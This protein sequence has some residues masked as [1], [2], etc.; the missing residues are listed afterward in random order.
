MEEF[1][2]KI[3]DNK[4]YY[5]VKDVLKYLKKSRKIIKDIPL[6]YRSYDI[7]DNKVNLYIR[8]DV[9]DSLIKLHSPSF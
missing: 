7:L 6:K 2:Y 8:E 9:I 3:Q 1:R 4:K 5:L